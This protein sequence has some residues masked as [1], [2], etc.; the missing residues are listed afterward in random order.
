[1]PFDTL[2]IKPLPFFKDHFYKKSKV[3]YKYKMMPESEEELLCFDKNLLNFN[4]LA[5]REFNLE[6]MDVPTFIK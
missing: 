6:V 4:L 3:E 1:M 5:R 2:K